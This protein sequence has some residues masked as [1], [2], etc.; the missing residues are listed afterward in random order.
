MNL[1]DRIVLSIKFVFLPKHKKEEII[2]TQNFMHN[3]FN[4]NKMCVR[5]NRRESMW[6]SNKCNPCSD[7]G[8]LE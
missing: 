7:I 3:H 4:K 8:W 5:C 2:S 1:I 6:Y